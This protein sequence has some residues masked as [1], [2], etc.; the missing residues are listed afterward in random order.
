MR[1]QAMKRHGGRPVHQPERD[2]MGR[3]EGGGFR[4]GN[5]YIL[6]VDSCWYIAKTVQYCKVKKKKKKINKNP[7]KKKRHRGN[8]NAYN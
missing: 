8:L 6:V 3:E 1:Y 5:S 4:M 7:K 2:G